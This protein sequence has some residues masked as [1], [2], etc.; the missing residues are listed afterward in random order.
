M[1]RKP[2]NVHVTTR[3]RAAASVLEP[4]TLMWTGY[5]A[6]LMFWFTRKR[7]DGSYFFFTFA[8]RS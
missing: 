8:R 2:G 3:G 4:H 5:L 7:F 1:T 6:G